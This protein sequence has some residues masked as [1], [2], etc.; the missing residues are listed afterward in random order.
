MSA[1]EHWQ[2]EYPQESV[3]DGEERIA[4]LHSRHSASQD[5]IRDDDTKSWRDEEHSK[6]SALLPMTNSME[7]D[8]LDIHHLWRHTLG[9]YKAN[10]GLLWIVLSQLCASCMNISVK[11]LNELDPPVPPLE[12]RID[13]HNA[14]HFTDTDTR[15]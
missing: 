4:F 1:S 14:S 11:I 3:E 12:V 2:A 15:K 9:V 8:D 6:H 13:E 7:T 10:I 5:V